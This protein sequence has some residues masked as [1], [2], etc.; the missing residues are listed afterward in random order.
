MSMSST[1]EKTGQQLSAQ[2]PADDRFEFDYILTYKYKQ[3]MQNALET[4]GL[5]STRSLEQKLA[6]INS[7]TGSHKLLLLRHFM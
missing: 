6:E 1:S 2:Q 3:L 4:V 7:Q 5:E